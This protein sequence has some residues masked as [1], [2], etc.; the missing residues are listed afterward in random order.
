[1]G[2]NLTGFLIRR[3]DFRA[4]M[5]R[6]FSCEETARKWPSASQEKRPQKKPKLWTS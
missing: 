4:L 3:K 6:K 1:M 2:P 5:H